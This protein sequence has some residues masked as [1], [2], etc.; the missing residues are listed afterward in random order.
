MKIGFD[1]EKYLRLQAEQ[2]R[3]RREQF[4]GKGRQRRRNCAAL[5]LFFGRKSRVMCRR[6]PVVRRP[7]A[8]SAGHSIFRHIVHF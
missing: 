7:E 8:A 2:I 3:R 5:P 4:G 1:N 6:R